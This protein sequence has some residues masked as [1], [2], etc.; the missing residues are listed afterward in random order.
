MS[1]HNLLA[2]L[3]DFAATPLSDQQRYRLAYHNKQ[4]HPYGS[5]RGYMWDYIYNNY[6]VWGDSDSDDELAGTENCGI[7]LGRVA[8]CRQELASS[9]VWW[10]WHA[11]LF[12]QPFRQVAG[13]HHPEYAEFR[14]YNTWSDGTGWGGYITDG[15]QSF[16]I[17]QIGHWGGGAPFTITP[18]N[19][20]EIKTTVDDWPETYLVLTEHEPDTLRY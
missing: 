16:K 5:Q 2:D 3:D 18:C 9:R 14:Y 17:E 11:V 6:D 7:S 12:N 13:Q 20:I 10:V 1:I 19:N 15:T 8:I 4:S